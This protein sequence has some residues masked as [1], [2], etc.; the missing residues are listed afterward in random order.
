MKIRPV[1]AELIHADRRTGGH[2]DRHDKPK[3]FFFV[4]LRTRLKVT[5]LFTHSLIVV[6]CSTSPIT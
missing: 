6:C 2:R 1:A 4:I 5:D 3:S